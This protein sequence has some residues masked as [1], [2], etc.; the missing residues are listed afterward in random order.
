MTRW[1]PCL[2]LHNRGSY[3]SRLSSFTCFG[4][5]AHLAFSCKALL[6]ILGMGRVR[7]DVNEHR[8][9]TSLL[10]ATRCLKKQPSGVSHLE[11]VTAHG[12]FRG[13]LSF[14]TR[15]VIDLRC[16]HAAMCVHGGGPNHAVPWP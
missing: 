12:G 16:A 13:K 3:V 4:M 15:R 1:E 9:R 14:G 11:V 6:P 7:V 8:S 10:N 2:S 5:Q